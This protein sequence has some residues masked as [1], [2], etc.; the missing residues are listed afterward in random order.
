[1]PAQPW[2]YEA[3]GS[4]EAGRVIE[5]RN[6]YSRGQK[7]IPQ[8][9]RGG[10]PTVSS[11]RK[12]AVLGALWRVRRTPPG[13]ESGACL[14]RG[15]SGTW[16]SHLSPCHRPGSGDR[17]TTGPGVLLGAST[18]PRARKGHHKRTEARKVSGSERQAKRPETG[19]V[20]VGAAQSTA[21]GGAVRPKRPT[22]GQAPSGRASAGKRQGRDRELTNPDHGRPVDCG[23]AA[24]ALS[25]EPEAFIAHVRVCG[26]AG[27]ET[28]GSTRQA[29][30]YSLRYAAA[31]GSA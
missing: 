24:A 19:R 22:G 29:T 31:S 8:G 27:W 26:G 20:A 11:G 12:A 16:E 13:S 17:V 10:K 7:D 18:R 5:P 15:N 9:S 6:E 23:R 25:E 2:A 30:A 28:T 14:H 1:M 4:E 21:E 3:G